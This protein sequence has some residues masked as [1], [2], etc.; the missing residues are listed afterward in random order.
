[1]KPI[2]IPGNKRKDGSYPVKIRVTFKGVTRRLPTSL[3]VTQSDLTRSL[4]IKNPNILMKAEYLITQMREGIQDLTPF[5]LESHDVDWIVSQMK[6]HIVGEQFHLDFF[7]WGYQYLYCK[8]EPT[9]YAY[10][11]ALNTFARFLGKDSLDIN[12]ISRTM[13]MEFCEYCEKQPKMHFNNHT[14]QLVKSSSEKIPRA[15]A[16]LH[17][18]KLQHIFNAAK[19]RYN[20]EDFGKILIPRSPFDTI[21]KYFPPPSTGQKNLGIDTMQKI[22][23]AQTSDGATRIALDAFVLSFCLMGANMADLFNATPFVGSEWRYNRQKTTSRRADKAEMRVCIPYQAKGAISRLQENTGA[24][25]LPM[26]HRLGK[27]KN[28]CTARTNKLLKRW[29]EKNGIAPFT[30]YAARH[31]WASLAR[32]V[33][34]EKATIDDALC[35]KGDFLMADIYAEK[36]WELVRQANDKVLALFVWED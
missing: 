27:D 10:K 3:V 25:W 6:K 26:L 19:D 20:D 18:M 2:V 28:T 16:S 36:S 12:E 4:K 11:T 8:S 22:I 5:E 31:T 32:S 35:H 7:Q 13:L 15:T 21:K 14:K 29:A 1:M 9:R 30:F 17:L 33:G 23:S 24:W 34:V